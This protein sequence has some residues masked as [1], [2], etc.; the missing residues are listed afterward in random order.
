MSDELEALRAP[1][2]AHE[3]IVTELHELC[4]C[5]GYG[6]VG[7]CVRC[8]QQRETTISYS[9]VMQLMATAQRAL[10]RMLLDS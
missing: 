10:D 2:C 8:D 7:R 3:W 9:Y 6:L 4:D 1:E 5:A